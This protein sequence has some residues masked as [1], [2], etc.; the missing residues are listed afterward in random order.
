MSEHGLRF[1]CPNGHLGFAPSKRES[2]D[3]GAATKPD[4][5][6]CDSGSSDIGPGPLGGDYS[7]SPYEWQKHDLE[8]MLVAARRQEVPMIIGSSGDTGTR[9]RVDLYVDIIKEL[10]V[11]HNLPPFNLAYFYSDV[12]IAYLKG[13][14]T[15][16]ETIEGLD[17]RKNLTAEELE[18][19]DR[20]V[21][22]AGIHPY[23]E[24][25]DMGADVI[26]GGRSSDI[27]I[28]AAPAIRK[29]YPEALAYYLG[30]ALECASFCAE[31]YGAKESV[32]GEITGEDVKLTAM[33][34]YQRCTV[35]S[36][37]GHAMYERSNPYFEHFAGGM[38]DMTNCHYEQYSEKTCRVTG[39]VFVPIEGRIKIKLEGSGKVGERYVGIAGV[40]DP[41]TIKNIDK[42]L[43]WSRDQVK[44]RFGDE[45][46]ELYYHVYGKNGVMGPL[47]PVKEIKS[48]ELCIVCQGVAPTAEMAEEIT[49][50][51]TRQIFYARLPEVK[52]TA[53]TAA[54][55]FE[56]V[57]LASV[58]YKWTLN[59]T[60]EVD[61]PM[62][63]F[64][65]H[66]TEVKGAR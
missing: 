20:I 62:E 23:I 53:G 50:T 63:L 40:R 28:F 49:M 32:I 5:Y 31:P 43:D 21:A 61:D 52:G 1:L 9:S 16:G 3:I 33:S 22:V 27:A 30:K 44:E 36:V 41:Y 10:A 17:G 29:G 65:L 6:C 48:H 57:F 39:P 25:L 54:F 59:H 66:I 58:A 60:V 64:D 8:M 4:F 46:Y 7:V 18:K 34:P 12:P 45:G 15:A 56:E 14:L 19:T 47:E 37:A 51:G 55:S 13:K 11:K 42:V 38:I 2:F 26:I 24:A 35:A